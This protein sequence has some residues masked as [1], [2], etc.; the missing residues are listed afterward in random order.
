MITGISALTKSSLQR[1]IGEDILRDMEEILPALL[2]EQEFSPNFL[3]EKSNLV[4]LVDAFAGSKMLTNSKM[5]HLLLYCQPKEV[6]DELCK[7]SGVGSSGLDFQEKIDKLM[8]KGW[9]AN[10]FSSTVCE[11]LGISDE[12]RPVQQ[13]KSPQSVVV[14][15][16]PHLFKQLKDYQFSVYIKASNLLDEPD[17][18]FI[19]QMPTG[20]GKTRTSMEIISRYLNETD[21]TVVWLA[22][23][24]ELCEQ[25][26]GCFEE[27][28]RHLGRKE[29][30]LC[31]QWG[32]SSSDKFGGRQQFVV[33]GFQKLYTD[34]SKQKSHFAELAKATGLVIVDE[35]HRVL[36]PTYSDV[37]KA[38]G[39]ISTRFIGLTATP[40]RS[41]TDIDENKKFSKFFHEE[42]IGLDSG[43]E[44]D[45]E[46]LRRKEVLSRASF[47]PLYTQRNFSLT[48][49]QKVHLEKFFDLPSSFLHSLGDDQIRNVEILK[50]LKEEVD[51]GRKILFFACSVKHSKYIAST[52]SFLGVKASH[53]DGSLIEGKRSQI[54]KSF[55]DGEIDV[56]ANYGVLSTGFDDPKV[57]VVFISRPTA[58]IVLYSQMIG[59]GLRGPAVGGTKHCKIID[60]IDNIDGYSNEQMVYSYFDDY[61]EHEG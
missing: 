21:K 43:S 2:Q 7:Q 11:V 29:I 24:A 25:A 38:L 60:T 4:K 10:Q 32:S 1:I 27:V 14:P 22:H 39:G 41:S 58:S 17:K 45:I 51:E 33:A 8:K 52:L 16:A 35:A 26:F 57:D 3:T 19:I 37:T 49:K 50:R 28:W 53:V 56:L 42:L 12:Y 36:A 59:R 5:R 23:S 48:P 13:V 15:P 9:G 20:S 61:F 40:G 44:G 47:T 54:I 18:R 31:R 6:I 30:E 55:K 34:Y 46:Y